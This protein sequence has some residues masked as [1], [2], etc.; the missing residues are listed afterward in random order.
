M[1]PV[2]TSP[3]GSR[4]AILSLYCV[5]SSPNLLRTSA[6]DLFFWAG[7]PCGSDKAAAAAA[8]T[9][10][11]DSFE[12]TKSAQDLGAAGAGEIVLVSVEGALSDST[13]GAGV[14]GSVDL[15]VPDATLPSLAWRCGVDGTLGTTGITGAGFEPFDCACDLAI[16]EGVV[17][18]VESASDCWKVV[19]VGV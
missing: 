14:A 4:N 8:L 1:F 6:R 11:A 17:G 9:A 13:T 2:L 18:C 3:R 15:G 5:T 19:V 12:R 10:L 16:D 7:S